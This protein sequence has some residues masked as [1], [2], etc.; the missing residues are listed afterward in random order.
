[1]RASLSAS[2]DY[3]TVDASAAELRDVLV[4]SAV[5]GDAAWEDEVLA[6]IIGELATVIVRSGEIIVARR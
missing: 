2:G 6:D 1:M 5:F 4:T 3:T